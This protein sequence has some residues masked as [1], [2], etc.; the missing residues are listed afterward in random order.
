MLSYIANSKAIINFY[1]KR[2]EKME[3]Y[4]NAKL[5]P[6]KTEWVKNKNHRKYAKNRKQLLT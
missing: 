5:K 1:A 3:S 4:K 2:V 6:Q